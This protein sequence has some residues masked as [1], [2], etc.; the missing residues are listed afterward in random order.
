MNDRNTELVSIGLPIYNGATYLEKALQS[1]LKQSYKNIEIVISDNNSTDGTQSVLKKYKNESRISFYKQRRT[2][3]FA[4]NYNFVLQKSK[5]E[6]FMWA[7]DDDIWDR[8][9]VTKLLAAMKDNHTFAAMSDFRLIDATGNIN[10]LVM[11]SALFRSWKTIS[12]ARYIGEGYFGLKPLFM[13]GLFKRSLLQSIHGFVTDVPQPMFIDDILVQKILCQSNIAIVPE[14][15][16]LKREVHQRDYSR[17]TLSDTWRIRL[18]IVFRLLR[19]FTFV[20]QFFFWK[21]IW[22]GHLGRLLLLYK[23]YELPRIASL[24]AFWSALQATFYWFTFDIEQLRRRC[25]TVYRNILESP[26]ASQESNKNTYFGV[27]QGSK[28]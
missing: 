13:C 16:Y 15:L 6:Y 1:L 26:Q 23:Q 22:R 9:F 7:A 11:P 28:K 12:L 18:S 8:N 14:V 3:S 2:L 24:Y 25:L 21:T 5:G 10:K 17:V 27:I 4:E 20:N 19:N